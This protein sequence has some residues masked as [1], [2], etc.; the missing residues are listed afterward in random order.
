MMRPSLDVFESLSIQSSNERIETFSI[1]YG[2]IWGGANMRKVQ[3]L[4]M[5]S[6][7]AETT[8]G[9]ILIAFLPKHGLR[10][11]L[12]VPNFPGGACPQ[13]P[14]ASSHLRKA[15]DKWVLGGVKASPNFWHLYLKDIAH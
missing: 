4:Q 9:Q 3:L 8:G 13:T 14:L 1:F 7:A 11:D 12:R 5:A 15:V 2:N 6:L 10:S